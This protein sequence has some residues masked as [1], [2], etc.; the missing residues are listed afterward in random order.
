M[1]SLPLAVTMICL[2]IE[3]VIVIKE[4]KIPCLACIHLYRL[5]LTQHWEPPY[6][7]VE[8][9]KDVELEGDAAEVALTSK[10]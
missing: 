1:T 3:L 10:S 8:P 6:D 4:L 9:D 5:T 2:P 7:C